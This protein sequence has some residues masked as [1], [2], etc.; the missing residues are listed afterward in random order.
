[1]FY[2]YYNSKTGVSLYHY[3]ARVVSGNRIGPLQFLFV[4]TCRPLLV[5][6]KGDTHMS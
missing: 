4:R 1:M 3:V 6:G 5:T 2:F